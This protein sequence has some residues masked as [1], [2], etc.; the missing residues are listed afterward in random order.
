MYVAEADRKYLWKPPKEEATS[1]MPRIRDT[2]EER[3][4]T[5]MLHW[6]PVLA[7]ERSLSVV[8][9]YQPVYAAYVASW[10]CRQALLD[11][12]SFLTSWPHSVW[13]AFQRKQAH[14]DLALRPAQTTLD[15]GAIDRMEHGIACTFGA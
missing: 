5:H 13:L 11:Y 10:P 9:Y 4:N 15:L 1:K 12:D 2:K 6:R 14:A 7:W 8:P 3:F